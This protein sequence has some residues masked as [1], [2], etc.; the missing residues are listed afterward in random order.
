MGPLIVD[1]L[2][3]GACVVLDFAGNTVV[4]RA[5]A[6]NLSERAGGSHI[7]HFLDFCAPECAGFEIDNA[8]VVE[9]YLPSSVIY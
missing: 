1:M 7:L 8:P 9:S 6:R 5:W 3:V 4:E 2:R